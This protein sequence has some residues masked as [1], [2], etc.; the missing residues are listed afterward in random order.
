VSLIVL[1]IILKISNYFF[2]NHVLAVAKLAKV[3]QK[4]IAH[5]AYQII[6]EKSLQISVNNAIQVV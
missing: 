2:V 4:S 3:L 1:Q 6:L 5:S